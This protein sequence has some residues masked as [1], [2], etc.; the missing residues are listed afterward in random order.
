MEKEEYANHN[1]L[2]INTADEQRKQEAALRLEGRVCL[3]L[4]GHPCLTLSVSL[5]TQQLVKTVG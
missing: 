1:E 2:K 5:S 4:D 3:L